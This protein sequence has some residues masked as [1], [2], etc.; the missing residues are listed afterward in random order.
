LAAAYGQ[1]MRTSLLLTLALSLSAAWADSDAGA[2]RRTVAPP[3]RPTPCDASK[4]KF[5]IHFEHFGLEE[6]AQIVASASCT[7]FDLPAEPLRGKI[8][9][10]EGR[11][12]LT[13]AAFL[14]LYLEAL[15]GQGYVTQTEGN[16]VRV[17]D[18]RR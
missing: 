1:T 2:G 5:N 7:T 16:R 4:A 3:I 8:S 14:G 10:T 15:K 9:N 6:L 12:P 17:L 18:A 11:D 13:S